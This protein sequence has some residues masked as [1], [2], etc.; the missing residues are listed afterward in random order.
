MHPSDAPLVNEQHLDPA[1]KRYWTDREYGKRPRTENEIGNRVWRGLRSLVGTAL[2]DESFGYRFPEQCLD[3]GVLCGCDQRAF[4]EMLQAE[5][6]GIEWPLSPQDEPATPVIL[7]VL[8]FCA[9]A[10]GKPIRGFHHDY[11]RHHHLTW[12]RESG[13]A[14]FV[15][16]VNL[17]FARNGVAYKLTKDGQARRLLS[18]PLGQA[19]RRAVFKTGDAETDQ[20]LEAARHRILLPKPED[21]RDALEKLWDAFERLKTL[22]AG[23]HKRAQAE[24][25]LDRA[26]GRGTRFRVLLGEEA[27][28]LTGI[29]NAFRIRHSETT[30]EILSSVEQVDYLFGRMF[31][32]IRMVLK[33][34]GRGG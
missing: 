7:D 21:R 12:D 10:V 20:L 28:A 15:S 8:E 29:G 17:V 34:T 31:F 13:L 5:V 18:Q 2:S 30:Q 32:F 16:D 9:S 33:A 23:P 27:A 1:M 19:L 22:E 3:G 25:L 6:P 4:A 24:A 11:Y 26:G 14:R